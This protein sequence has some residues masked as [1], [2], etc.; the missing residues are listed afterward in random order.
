MKL[1]TKILLTILPVVLTAIGVLGGLSIR[2]HRATLQDAV[3]Q[4]LDGVVTTYVSQ[5]IA[6]QH[7]LLADH[8]LDAVPSYVTRYQD[9]A[10]ASAAD[11]ELIWEGGI[12]VFSRAGDLLHANEEMAP[13]AGAPKWRRLVRQAAEADDRF[14]GR[15]T[16]NDGSSFLYS[17]KLFDPWQWAV[18]AVVQDAPFVAA[19]RHT[20]NATLFVALI[21]AAVLV[22][23]LTLV[24]QNL[25]KR[26]LVRM[27][28]AADALAARQPVGPIGASSGDEI[29]QLARRFDSMAREVERSRQRLETW[30]ED[31]QEAVAAQTT[32]LDDA[33]ARLAREIDEKTIMLSDLEVKNSELERFVYTVSHDLRSPIITIRGFLGVMAEDLERGSLGQVK[34]HMGRVDRA[35]RTMQTL[36]DSLLELSRIGRV[37]N[38]SEAVNLEALA[39]D[40]VELLSQSIA[41][42]GV[43]VTIRPGLP[44]VRCDRQRVGEVLQN[45]VENAVKF[46]GDQPAPAV[47]IGARI[48][49]G[50]PVIYVRDNGIGIA[51]GYREKIFDMFHQLDAGQPGTGVGLALV[52]RIVEHHGGSIWAASDGP[53]RGS[54]FFFTLGA[55]AAAAPTDPEEDTHER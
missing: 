14:S 42:R 25:V 36:L 4:Y 27:R 53:G 47:E 28:Q 24:F 32:A 31:L 9:E 6:D 26:P 7:R 1:Q 38:A 23:C 18:V 29:G 3:L 20:R 51:E 37:V 19:A 41:D 10:A 54:T 22:A 45:L 11:V 55:A 12:V 49:N 34:D 15:L 16:L 30:N 50:E 2:R 48:R 13:L 40:V 43:S 17:G 44:T 39:A 5:H 46:M 35:A 8:R 21:S 52:R 33:N